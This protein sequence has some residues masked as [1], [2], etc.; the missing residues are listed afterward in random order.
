MLLNLYNSVLLSLLPLTLSQWTPS[1]S[2]W[3]GWGE[4]TPA[5]LDIDQL[6]E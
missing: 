1:K 2:Q 3:T 5:L 6:A 4:Q